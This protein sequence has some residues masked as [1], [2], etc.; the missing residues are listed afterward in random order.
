[1]NAKVSQSVSYFR[2]NSRL[3]LIAA[4]AA[5]IDR[6]FALDWGWFTA[7]VLV[8]AFTCGLHASANRM[9]RENQEETVQLDLMDQALRDILGKEPS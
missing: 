1:V 9:L 6:A 8:T 5:L 4:F 3:F 7:I 2:F